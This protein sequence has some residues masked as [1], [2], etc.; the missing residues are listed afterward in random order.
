MIP[1]FFNRL[2]AHQAV[3]LAGCGGGYD[4]VNA[5]PI[6]KFLL[7]RGQ[8]VVLANLSF[9]DLDALP[10][11]GRLQQA[12]PVTVQSPQL[13]YFPEKHLLQWLALQ[14]IDCPCYAVSSHWGC[15]PIRASYQALI[16]QHR[17]D[18][19]VLM[20]GGTDSLMFGDERAVA[21]IVEDS[22]STVAVS[23][24]QHV[25]SYLCATAFGIE[26]NHQFDHYACLENIAELT[27]TGAFL[28]SIG[29]APQQTEAQWIASLVAYL[30]AAHPDH[31][32]IVANAIHAAISGQFGDVHF[33]ER[34]A[35]SPQFINPLM[36]TYWFFALNPI[37][38][39]IVFADQIQGSQ[40]MTEVLQAFKLWRAMNP[41]RRRT[42]QL[43]L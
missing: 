9:T 7:D 18:A 25:T 29:I 6:L 33:S 30:N 5:L 28:G 23:G 17:L 35:G 27:R 43:M 34:T 15:A 31:Q 37:A 13:G 1:E 8:R 21:T 16:D 24:L 2:A 12:V 32:S 36:A 10:M 19:V 4:L 20:D 38:D 42:G 14:G 3:L 41:H 11:E 40:L 39:R 26:Q 22:A